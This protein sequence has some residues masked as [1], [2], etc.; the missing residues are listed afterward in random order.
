MT[1][2]LRVTEHRAAKQATAATMPTITK[3]EKRLIRG[4]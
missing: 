3:I 4:D 1:F 2:Q